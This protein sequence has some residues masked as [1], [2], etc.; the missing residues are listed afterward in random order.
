MII[1]KFWWGIYS[2]FSSKST[3]NKL[4]SEC[5]K[6]RVERYKYRRRLIDATH[7]H[8]YLMRYTVDIDYCALLSTISQ[9]SKVLPKMSRHCNAGKMQ[10]IA[11]FLS[12]NVVF[13]QVS[14]LILSSDKIELFSIRKLSLTWNITA[15]WTMIHHPCPVGFF[16]FVHRRPS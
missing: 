7:L 11:D 14:N 1:H 8:I 15:S 13:N 9:R 12:A 16:T 2:H 6:D 3:K 5:G 4:S 10:N